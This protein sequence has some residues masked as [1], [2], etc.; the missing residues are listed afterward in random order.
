[1]SKFCIYTVSYIY[2]YTS[3]EGWGFLLLLSKK[4]TFCH[5]FFQDKCATTRKMKRLLQKKLQKCFI[6]QV[7]NQIDNVDYVYKFL[8]LKIFLQMNKYVRNKHFKIFA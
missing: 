2:T 7:K 6:L 4:T 3:M 5:D 1:M 8:K